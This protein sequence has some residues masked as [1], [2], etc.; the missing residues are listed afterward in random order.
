ME[1][2]FPG[3]NP[4]MERRWSDVHVSLLVSIVEGLGEDV[5]Y[6]F[7][8]RVE[9]V[10]YA[11]AVA[12]SGLVITEPEVERWI[13]IRDRNEKLVTAIEVVKPAN[14]ID[15]GYSYFRKRQEKFLDDG[16][17]QVELD[18]LRNGKPTSEGSFEFLK[19]R[20][21]TYYTVCARRAHQP[22][23]CEVYPIHLSEPLPTVRIPL[24]PGD[25]D[26][27]LA[28]QPLIDKCYRTGRYWQLDHKVELLDPPLPEDEA[29]WVQEILEESFDH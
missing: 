29:K 17:N 12:Q 22:E 7:S 21:G 10:E 8:I 2:P 15:P 11:G 13:E 26:V 14:K 16:G 24:R 25:M 18:L 19:D 3:M 20:E 23:L 4:F 27:P 5:S 28:I 1:N 9:E 6:E